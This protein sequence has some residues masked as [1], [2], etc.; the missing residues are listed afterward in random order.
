MPL[1]H[2]YALQ[3]VTPI[4]SL[5]VRMPRFV[6]GINGKS[7]VLQLSVSTRKPSIASDRAQMENGWPQARQMVRLRSGTWGTIA[8]FRALICQGNVQLRLNLIPNTSHWPMA[9]QIELS[10]TGT[11]KISQAS[12]RP[13]PTVLQSRICTSVSW[14]RSTFMLSAK[15]IWKFGI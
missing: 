5:V 10:S 7:S 13:K 15:R 9:Q 3:W 8:Y 1:V 2:L 6:S 14:T 12:I 11:W 4:F